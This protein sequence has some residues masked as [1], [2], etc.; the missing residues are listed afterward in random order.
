MAELKHRIETGF[1]RFG[2]MI[3]RNPWKTLALMVAL[4]AALVSQ[5]RFLTQDSSPESF[6]HKN[7]PE[8]IR[9][10]AFKAQFGRDEMVIAILQ[11]KEV[12]DASF[13]RKVK[14]FH[15][16]LDNVPHRKKVTSLINVRHTYGKGDTL[17]V[18]DRIKEIP[19]PPEAMAALKARV[20]ASKL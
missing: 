20:M 16:A 7:D 5:L 8:L 17:G 3:Y 12:F 13:L 6:F 2:R 1:A 15:D 11:P 14:S 9:Y 4:T 18:E 19:A 10:N